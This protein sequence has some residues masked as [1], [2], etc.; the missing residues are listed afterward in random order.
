M[1]IA[2]RSGDQA[3]A[4]V[5]S[6]GRGPERICGGPE[7]SIPL[8]ALR[9]GFACRQKGSNEE[10]TRRWAGERR[11]RDVILLN[12]GDMRNG[13]RRRISPTG[14]L[15]FKKRGAGAI[16][17]G[18]VVAVAVNTNWLAACVAR[19]LW[20]RGA[21]NGGGSDLVGPA[22][23]ALTGSA[24]RRGL[25]SARADRLDRYRQGKAVYLSD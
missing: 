12:N 19:C 5:R 6:S 20:P 11:R 22:D 10:L 24:V 13:L 7:I 4:E 2:G 25:N 21:A 8:S 9:F 14:S 1:G 15:F 23:P 18:H 3:T 16:D 17:A